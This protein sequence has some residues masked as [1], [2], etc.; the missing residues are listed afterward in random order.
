MNSGHSWQKERGIKMA[1][2]FRTSKIQKFIKRQVEFME[3]QQKTI[4]TLKAEGVAK[5]V[6][7]ILETNQS[8]IYTV[9]FD[10]CHEF[11]L[12]MPIVTGVTK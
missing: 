4:E 11:G 2:T 1:E 5:E 3:L 9:V 6:I 12:E 10:L 7:T 8:A